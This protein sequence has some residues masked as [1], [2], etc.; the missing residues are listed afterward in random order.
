MLVATTREL[1]LL[2][3]L[4]TPQAIQNFLDRIPMN[5]EKRGET[6]RSALAALRARKAHCV[7]GAFIAALA[8]K[9]NG[10]KPLV[11][12]MR[13]KRPDDDHVISLYKINGY[14]GAISKTNHATIRYRDPVYKTTR[15][16]ALSYF[17]EWF[18]NKT[19]EKTL[20]SFSDP[21]NLDKTDVDWI[22][23]E[24]DLWGIDRALNRAKHHA[25]APSK[26]L[27]M[28]RRADPMELKAGRFVEW[29]ENDPRT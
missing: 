21:I 9:L 16:L 24:G 6:H 26:N 29:K 2:K 22:S 11:M 17:H 5:H 12:D 3:K 20:R 15:E 28:S 27:R 8:L 23:G 10:H 14:W 18:V 13:A 1:S 4:K 19:G 25:I 7:E